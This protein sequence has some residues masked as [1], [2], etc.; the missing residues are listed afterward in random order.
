MANKFYN[1]LLY[2]LDGDSRLYFFLPGLKYIK[3]IYIYIY[4]KVS[5]IRN[6]D[7]NEKSKFFNYI[8]N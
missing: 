4:I 2:K 3:F 8:T 7:K 6:E 1:K 5:T